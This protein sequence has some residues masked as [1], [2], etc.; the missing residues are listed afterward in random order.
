MLYE[1]SINQQRLI[2]FMRQMIAVSKQKIFL[3]V[4][5]IFSNYWNNTEYDAIITKSRH[6]LCETFWYIETQFHVYTNFTPFEEISMWFSNFL[7]KKEGKYRIWYL[8]IC[9]F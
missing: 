4:D 2:Q 1:D 9:I 5:R 3:I 7:W 8:R 6:I